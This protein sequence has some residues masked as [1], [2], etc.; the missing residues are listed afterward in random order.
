MDYV[1]FATTGG[2]IGCRQGMFSGYSHNSQWVRWV[3]GRQKVSVIEEALCWNI[4]IT[5]YY[6]LLM[7]QICKLVLNCGVTNTYMFHVPCSQVSAPIRTMFS[8]HGSADHNGCG[9]TLGC[10]KVTCIHTRM[11]VLNP[12]RDLEPMPM[13]S[14]N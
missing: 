10:L 2:R 8:R 3:G 9:L 1:F 13:P 6:G 4:A 5:G 11:W 12:L 14:K 7:I